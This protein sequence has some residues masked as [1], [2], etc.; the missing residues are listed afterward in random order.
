MDTSRILGVELSRRGSWVAK[1]DPAD[2]PS[3]RT[4]SDT[5]GGTRVLGQPRVR[6]V[7]QV[8]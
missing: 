6:L 3:R 2:T 5:P 4:E 8:Q 7:A 1:I